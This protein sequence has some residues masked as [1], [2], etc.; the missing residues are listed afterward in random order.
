MMDELIVTS[1]VDAL[2]LEEFIEDNV[3]TSG[4]LDQYEEVHEEFKEAFK[5]DEKMIKMHQEVV[6]IL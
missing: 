3:I 4:N 6:E 5:H 1:C 2:A